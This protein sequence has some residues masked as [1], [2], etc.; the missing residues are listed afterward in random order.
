M[1]NKKT[2]L[3]KFMLYLCALTFT[4]YTF[5]VSD[6]NDML[7]ILQAFLKLGLVPEIIQNG[8]VINYLE[9]PTLQIRFL[10]IGC[11]LK[12]SIYQMATQY[13]ITHKK[14]YFP[15]SWNCV[16]KY[17]YDGLIPKL[18]DFFCYSDTK[19]ERQ[20][21][22]S[23]YVSLTG[24]WNMSNSLI[25]SL[26][27]DTFI[28]VESALSFVRQCFELQTLISQ[29]TKQNNGEIHPFGWRISSL[30]SFTY[31]VYSLFYLNKLEMYSVMNPYTGGKS[32][33][34]QGEYEWLTWLNWKNYGWNIKTAFNSFEGQVT[35][36]K[37]AVDGYSENQKTVYQFQGCEFHYHDPSKCLD[38]KNK[39]RTLTS[40]NCA[41]K[42]LLELKLSHEK[43]E[44]LLIK[45]FPNQVKNVVYQYSCLWDDF[46]KSNPTEMT[47]MWMA[48]DFDSKRPLIR[49][50]PRATLRGG[51]IE[52]YR[53]KFTLNDYPGWSIQF[54]DVNSLYS[55][56]A[57]HNK[58]PV[59]KYQILLPEHNFKKDITFV[60][61]EFFYKGQ[62][63]QGD[64]AHVKFLAP[65]KL[66]KP[67]LGYR[68]NDEYNFLALCKKCVSEKRASQCTHF[69]PSSRAFTSCYQVTDLAK[70]VSLG[71]EIL[72]WYELHHYV[73]REP[74]L[75]EFVQILGIEKIKNYNILKTNCDI[76]NDLICQNINS[77]MNLPLNLSIQNTSYVCNPAQKQLYKDMM[78]SFFGRF[79][80]HT[81][82]KHHYFCR[83]LFDIQRLAAKDNCEI[84]DIFPI[85]ENFC[86]IELNEPT[87]IK[88]NIE[89]SL[90]ITSEIN[91]LARKYIYDKM[92][93]IK[94]VG[95]IIIGVDTDAIS[96]ALPPGVSDILCYSDAF[97]DFKHVLGEQSKITSFYSLGPRNYSITYCENNV[98]KH[99]IKVKGLCTTSVNTDNMLSPTT[100][101]DFLEKRFQNQ[102]DSIYVPQMRK[103]IDKQHKHFF[104]I[105]THFEFG[106]EIHTKRYVKDCDTLFVTYPYGFK[107]INM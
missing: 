54:A 6:N 60:N 83:N 75:K 2:A 11:Y 88:P 92:E 9:I 28:F 52:Q 95:G 13:N 70:A 15:N 42:T 44:E 49:L 98:E 104:E 69:Q 91:A 101:S 86:E 27:N 90:Y 89:G 82:F 47:A 32:Q 93:L 45:H 41:N 33:T 1:S 19:E 39:K 55:S 8:N 5:I 10:I 71:Y 23:F 81:N 79:A 100:Y 85:S 18:N 31:S 53:L 74:I 3:D 38:P 103:K 106:N 51:F 22:I 72:D 21:K 20:F 63:M 34:S 36:G 25:H 77:K 73:T 94:S 76:E 105:L 84:V 4:N 12:G 107:F 62:S 50:V 61:N 97:G 78:N 87:K 66:D 37:R 65:T 43:E 35:L 29:V 56:I 80:L 17:N 58:F 30:S 68:L 102:F 7:T 99:L 40:T 57:I 24:S 48:T 96:Y 64:A 67:F 26:Q 14:I 46:K 59:G 16:D